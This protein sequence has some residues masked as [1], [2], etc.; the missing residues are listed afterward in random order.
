MSS[1]RLSIFRHGPVLAERTT[2]GLG[3]RCLA[4]AVVRSEADLDALGSFVAAE[5]G[6]PFV[7]GGG[8]NLLAADTE[9]DLIILS[10]ANDEFDVQGE[11]VRVGAGMK[12]PVLLTRLQQAGLSGLEGLAGIPGTVGGALAMNA[13]SWGTEFGMRV[14]R[15]GLWTP[16][17][18]LAWIGRDDLSFGYRRFVPDIAGK[19]LAWNV[20]L[21]LDKG[22]PAA[23]KA[24]MAENIAKKK[25][26]QPVGQRTAGCVFKN[27]KG[28]AAG[29]LLDGAGMKGKAVGDMEFSSLHANFMVNRGKGSFTQAVEL[30][31][32]GR[33][34]VMDQFGVEL[35]TEVI[36][37]S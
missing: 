26:G 19:W 36:V 21:T 15:A 30:M 5:R 31:E 24:A 3:G 22:D 33:Q 32:M 12:L 17:A 14:S 9:L 27:P 28:D 16:L 10:V 4:E 34:A 11:T 2:L 18:G 1:S 8:S 25:A 37:L 29:R 20:E 7:L 23:I 35:E 6:R 13:G